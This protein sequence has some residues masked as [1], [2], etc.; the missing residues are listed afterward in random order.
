LKI[1]LRG[2]FVFARKNPAGTPKRE[3]KI[4]VIDA[5]IR[6]LEITFPYFSVRKI[7]R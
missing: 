5:S 2:R 7:S 6:L 3:D 4:V 1:F